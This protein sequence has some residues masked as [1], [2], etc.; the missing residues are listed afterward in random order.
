MGDNSALQQSRHNMSNVT[1]L[2][3]YVNVYLSQWPY[4]KSA[5]SDEK[6]VRVMFHDSNYT[7]LLV[8]KG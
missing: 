2:T 6:L 3:Y 1:T 8:F 5:S 4:N 7:F